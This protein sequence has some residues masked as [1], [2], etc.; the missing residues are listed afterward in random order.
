[1]EVPQSKVA[2]CH[3][4]LK[5]S[6]MIQIGPDMIRCVVASVR[7]PDLCAACGGDGPINHGTT[8]T[9]AHHC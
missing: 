2:T 4:Q 6:M 1:M 3:I 8:S 5:I 9:A 7:S